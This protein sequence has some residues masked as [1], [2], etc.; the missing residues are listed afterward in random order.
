MSNNYLY[1]KYITYMEKYCNDRIYIPTNVFNIINKYNKCSIDL[2][3]NT[4]T[5]KII[6]CK[7]EVKYINFAKK[8]TSIQ[9][10]FCSICYNFINDDFNLI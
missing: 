4:S 2:C 5:K 1:L 3:N 7:N 8:T 6:G 10:Y 9:Q